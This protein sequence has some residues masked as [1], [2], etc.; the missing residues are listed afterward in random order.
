MPMVV[1]HLQ[2]EVVVDADG[3]VMSVAWA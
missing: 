2:V 1:G 3:D